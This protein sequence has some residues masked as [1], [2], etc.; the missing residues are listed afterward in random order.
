MFLKAFLWGLNFLKN[1]W[2]VWNNW[3][4]KT[5]D[6]FVCSVNGKW[7]WVF[8]YVWTRSKFDWILLVEWQSGMSIKQKN[9]EIIKSFKFWKWN[10]QNL[11]KVFQLKLSFY[12]TNQPWERFC[13]EFDFLQKNF[14]FLLFWQFLTSYTFGIS[15]NLLNYNYFYWFIPGITQITISFS[16]PWIIDIL[17]FLCCYLT[18]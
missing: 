8:W 17:F 4:F 14:F 5:I 10:L 6:I 12:Q 2:C 9:T 11:R 16:L 1:N 15:K 13:D 7:S 3:V 18:G